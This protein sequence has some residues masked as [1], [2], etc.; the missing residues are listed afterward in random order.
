M[1]VIGR[2]TLKIVELP[3][4]VEISENAGESVSSVLSE[5]DVSGVVMLTGRKSYEVMGEKIEKK[6]SNF[7]V[8]RFFV[9]K[10]S[11]KEV[12]EIEV[13]LGYFSEIDC[14]IGV[15]G[16]KVL[17]VAKVLA[18]EIN[19]AFISIPTVASHDGIAS[20]VASFKEE[21]KPVSITTKPPAALLADLTVLKHSPVRLLRS[22]YGDL[23]SNVTAVK[24]W[25]LAREKTGE[26]FNEVAASMAVLPANL[27]LSNAEV[28]DLKEIKYLEMLI[29]GLTLS[30]VAISIAGSSRPASG[31]EHKFS[32]ALDYLNYGLGTHGEQVALGTIIMEYLHEKHYGVGNWEKIKKSLEKIQAPTTA[33][34]I[35]LNKNQILEA[36]EYAKKIRKKRYTIL[37]DVNPNKDEFEVV[38]RKTEIV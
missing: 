23:I 1:K 38:L 35:G 29:R 12:R 32:H 19:A 15:G 31:A 21:G 5:L 6:V 33:R 28:I 30:G 3:L 14:V 22:G 2:S 11:M 17:D 37:E 9:E 24:D 36:L 16:G 26:G 7:L 34:E 25:Q 18:T 27:M 20:P 4:I 8:E 13:K 10:P